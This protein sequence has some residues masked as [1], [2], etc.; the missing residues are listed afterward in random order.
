MRRHAEAAS[1][2]VAL[3]VVPSRQ[4]AHFACS[5]RMSASYSI[6]GL[7]LTCVTCCAMLCFAP[8]PTDD[9]ILGQIHQLVPLAVL[10]LPIN[11]LVYTLDGVLV[12]ASDFG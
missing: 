6:N 1:S 10:P 12:G 2:V 11:A 3:P 9:N 8:L 5:C 7:V 4:H